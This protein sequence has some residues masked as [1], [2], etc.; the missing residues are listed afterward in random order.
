MN[1]VLRQDTK[2]EN[3]TLLIWKII[4]L[5]KYTISIVISDPSTNKKWIMQED[6]MKGLPSPRPGGSKHLYSMG[7]ES[8]S[9]LLF[10]QPAK[11]SSTGE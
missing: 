9:T 11:I 3:S 1:S 2:S 8:V 10:S 5:Y 4:S 7:R 6:I